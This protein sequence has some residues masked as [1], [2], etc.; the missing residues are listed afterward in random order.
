MQTG[1]T[2]N[3]NLREIRLPHLSWSWVS[4]GNPD[5]ELTMDGNLFCSESVVGS[6]GKIYSRRSVKLN[7]I[8]GAVSYYV[9]GVQMNCQPISFKTTFCSENDIS[10]LLSNFQSTKLCPGF[11]V[12]QFFGLEISSSLLGFQDEQIIRS[13]NCNGISP[14]S[15]P[16]S[17]CQSMENTI[18]KT[19]SNNENIKKNVGRKKEGQFL[20]TNTI[21]RK[22]EAVK[23]K[24]SQ[25]DMEITEIEVEFSSNESFVLL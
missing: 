13:P 24:L 25:E 7:L 9:F 11:P 2:N 1:P 8:S 5:N 15:K 10:N 22:L 3:I 14:D 12:P 23:H 16:C 18:Q 19:K 21:T 4:T 20:K 6:T 17:N